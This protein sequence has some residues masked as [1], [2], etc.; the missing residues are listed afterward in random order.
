MNMIY[1][2][3]VLF[4]FLCCHLE[5]YTAATISSERHGKEEATR[6]HKTS[7]PHLEKIN[8]DLYVGK[9]APHFYLAMER[10]TPENIDMWLDYADRQASNGGI[11][12]KYLPDA[13]GSRYF[14]K[15]LQHYKSGAINKDANEL[16]VAYASD[17]PVTKK[18][19]LG[20][21]NPHIEMFVTVTTAPESPITFHMGISRTWEAAID[22][23]ERSERFGRPKRI[24]HPDQSIHL[25]SFAAKVMKDINPKRVWM[26]TTPAPSMGKI[27][28]NKMPPH[29]TFIGDNLYQEGV[30]V[31]QKNPRT[32][33]NKWDL[34]EWPGES[35]EK[36]EERLDKKA[37]Q[38]YISD[39]IEEKV[40]LLKSNPPRIIRTKD[41]KNQ[42][43]TFQNPDG[44]PLITVDQSNPQYQWLFIQDFLP[45][46][47]ELAYVLTD[48]TMLAAKT[49]LIAEE[50]PAVTPTPTPTTTHVTKHKRMIHDK[51]QILV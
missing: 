22:L 45:Y 17:I 1:R 10:V 29:S 27:L 12:P 47:I 38:R 35:P 24:K 48:L 28:L 34:S 26:L 23:E 46:G 11:S 4:M 39:E 49:S 25:H 44:S 42:Q 7:F 8:D 15:A 31:A 16:W 32:R 2:L 50:A 40:K 21:I 51:K 18:A 37:Q 13:G 41:V 6:T 9:A 19:H 3:S 20:E 43:I 36:R 5:S 14:K 33:L 30:N